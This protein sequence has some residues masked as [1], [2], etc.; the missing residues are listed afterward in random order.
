MPLSSVLAL[1]GT[2]S[3]TSKTLGDVNFDETLN[4]LLESKNRTQ[5]LTQKGV[6]LDGYYIK[7]TCNLNAHVSKTVGGAGAGATNTNDDMYEFEA[8]Q[9]EQS[10]FSDTFTDAGQKY[11]STANESGAGNRRWNNANAFS[12]YRLKSFTSNVQLG[13]ISLDASTVT[14]SSLTGP[15]SWKVTQQV[16]NE[17]LP[18][19]ASGFSVKNLLVFAEPA[20]ESNTP[21]QNSPLAAAV[22][23][24]V[25]VAQY[26]YVDSS[27]AAA[28]NAQQHTAF[29]GDSK[30]KAGGDVNDWIN[31]SADN[32]GGQEAIDRLEDKLSVNITNADIA[33]AYSAEITAVKNETGL[34]EAPNNT[35][36]KI[37][38]SW[39]VNIGKISGPNSAFSAHARSV[40]ASRAAVLRAAGNDADADALLASGGDENTP[41]FR[42]QDMIVL[43][44]PDDH[45]D[46]ASRGEPIAVDLTLTMKQQTGAGA[47][48]ASDKTLLSMTKAGTDEALRFVLEQQ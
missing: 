33:K 38:T 47:N 26:L 27:T 41:L 3:L 45:A 20:V 7:V 40:Y 13:I 29:G 10:D 4:L 9:I 31:T 35:P 6:D 16:S 42:S 24:D 22:Q 44:H 28:G 18:G 30:Y 2:F 37:I 39:T 5:A 43:V 8:L 23:E 36:H 1:P 11:M 25:T 19:D 21:N 17:A 32:E 14:T 46:E 12:Q 48:A 34:G 15:Q